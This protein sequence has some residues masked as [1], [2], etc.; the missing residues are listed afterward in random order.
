ME[1]YLRFKNE[2]SELNQKKLGY[3]DKANRCQHKIDE[4]KQSLMFWAEINLNKKIR[5]EIISAAE[6]KGISKATIKTLK[7]LNDSWEKGNKCEE[8]IRLF[9][10]YKLELLDEHKNKSSIKWKKFMLFKF[11]KGGKSK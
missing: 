11:K 10:N 5:E 9:V 7:E 8:D 6:I 2:I 3:L 4:E 1:E